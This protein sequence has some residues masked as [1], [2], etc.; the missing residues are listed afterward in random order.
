MEQTEIKTKTFIY[1]FFHPETGAKLNIWASKDEDA[2]TK[3]S[4]VVQNVIEW[5]LRKAAP[6]SKRSKQ[7]NNRP[8]TKM[9]V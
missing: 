1:R 2:M 6:S 3:F 5:K 9:K 7:R 8:H 4:T